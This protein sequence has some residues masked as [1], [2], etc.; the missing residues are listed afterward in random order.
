M[1]LDI[2]CW[3][4]NSD[5]DLSNR[6]NNSDQPRQ[7]EISL[8]GQETGC[9]LGH[10]LLDQTMQ[11]AKVLKQL[12]L[13]IGVKNKNGGFRS[14]LDILKLES[15]KNNTQGVEQELCKMSFY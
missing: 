9:Y 2:G 14:Q 1:G 12:L 7:F 15:S 8:S 5:Y 11:V 6:L 13:H 4:H 10:H 3:I